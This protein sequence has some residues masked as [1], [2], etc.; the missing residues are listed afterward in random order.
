M[1]VEIEEEQ[2][3][4]ILDINVGKS[5]ASIIVKKLSND[6]KSTNLLYIWGSNMYG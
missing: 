6:N 1:K 4:H 5:H 3:I 2:Q